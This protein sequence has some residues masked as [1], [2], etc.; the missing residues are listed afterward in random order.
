[1]IILTFLLHLIMLVQLCLYK[2]SLSFRW[3][4][5]VQGTFYYLVRFKHYIPYL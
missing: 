2:K 5:S 4:A 1:M 3:D